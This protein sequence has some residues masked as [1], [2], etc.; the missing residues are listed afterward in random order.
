[1]SGLLYFIRVLGGGRLL[2]CLRFCTCN[3]LSGEQQ[4]LTGTG[5][6]FVART[7]FLCD[8]ISDVVGELLKLCIKRHEHIDQGVVLYRLNTLSVVAVVVRSRR[9][10]H[11]GIIPR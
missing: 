9:W 2:D 10:L 6:A 5:E 11:C 8:D 3:S 1:M 7:I 4:K